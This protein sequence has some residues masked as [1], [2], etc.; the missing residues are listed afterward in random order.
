MMVLVEEVG[1]LK[2]DSDNKNVSL[3]IELFV[4]Y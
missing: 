3:S 2:G 4:F 1:E